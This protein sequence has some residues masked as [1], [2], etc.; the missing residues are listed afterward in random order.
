MDYLERQE[1]SAE[2][3]QNFGL[4][5]ARCGDDTIRVP[6]SYGMQRTAVLLAVQERRE[7]E[8]EADEA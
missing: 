8:S 2:Y 5:T 4:L 7:A 1:R 6:H 3:A